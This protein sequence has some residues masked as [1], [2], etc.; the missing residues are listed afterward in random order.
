[1]DTKQPPLLINTLTRRTLS[2]I[3]SLEI[4]RT[5]F[6]NYIKLADLLILWLWN[7]EKAGR[8]VQNKS[9]LA[10]KRCNQAV[11]TAATHA[12]S[13]SEALPWT[14]NRRPWSLGHDCL[15]WREWWLPL[16]D[17]APGAVL[18]RSPELEQWSKLRR[19]GAWSNTFCRERRS[20]G[21]AGGMTFPGKKRE[22]ERKSWFE[23]VWQENMKLTWNLVMGW[24][25]KLSPTKKL[26]LLDK[27]LH[28]FGVKRLH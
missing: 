12:P 23:N 11:P 14:W 15:L 22:R 27:P 18:S 9:F 2:Q 25:A 3:C 13:L 1:M 4:R 16:A 7:C 6:L 28:S 24:E 5:T 20:L 10:S 19:R 26:G 8:A 21:S 17:F